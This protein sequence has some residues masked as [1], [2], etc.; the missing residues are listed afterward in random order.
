M[1]Y[2]TTL[3]IVPDD[4]NCTSQ[5]IQPQSVPSE[6]QVC[7][8]LLLVMTEVHPLLQTRK[9]LTSGTKELLLDDY[10]SP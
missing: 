1:Q 9:R 6:H 7:G 3:M 2:L 8:H 10:Q 5:L 4:D